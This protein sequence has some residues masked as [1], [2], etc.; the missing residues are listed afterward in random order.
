V[1]GW[2]TSRSCPAA[3]W[4]C[5]AGRAGIPHERA[6]ELVFGADFGCNLQYLSNRIPSRGLRGP[7]WAP[8]GRKSAEQPGAGSIFLSSL[9]SAQAWG[10]ARRLCRATGVPRGTWGRRLWGRQAAAGEWSLRP[11]GRSGGIAHERAL[12]VVVGATLC[13]AIMHRGYSMLRN[14]ASG[15]WNGSPPPSRGGLGA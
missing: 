12:E 10:L 13:Y 6:S 15:S 11:V 9:K 3:G 7:P 5:S 4:N 8:Q 14:N 1:A 2:P